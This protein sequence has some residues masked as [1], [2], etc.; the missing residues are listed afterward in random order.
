MKL[1]VHIT[2]GCDLCHKCINLLR[3][4]SIMH[5]VVADKPEKIRPYPYIVMEY[6]YEELV[7]MIAKGKL[8][9]GD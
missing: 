7:D 3:H 5:V 6:E 8:N 1:V 4:W 9:W 2:K